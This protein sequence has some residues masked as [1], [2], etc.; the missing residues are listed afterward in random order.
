[1]VIEMLV[2]AAPNFRSRV[3][4]CI[5]GLSVLVG[6]DI[7][8]DEMQTSQRQAYLV[9]G[10]AQ[11]HYF[12]LRRGAYSR[13]VEPPGGPF[14]QR[15]GYSHL[16]QWTQ[17]LGEEDFEITWRAESSRRARLANHFGLY[18]IYRPT[19]QAGLTILSDDGVKLYDYG[20][21][22]FYFHDFEELPEL[23][24]TTLLFIENRELLEE[25]YDY[26]NPAVEW[27]RF[28]QAALLL[29]GGR[30]GLNTE[31][32][33]GSTLA[34][35]LEKFRHSPGG[36]TGDEREKARQMATATLRAYQA[37]PE[38]T[39]HRQGI[40]LDYVNE[41]P[42]AASPG[43]GEVLGLA[44]GLRVWFGAEPQEVMERLERIHHA[45]NQN[46]KTPGFLTEQ[47]L[48]D[49]RAYRM[50]LSLF[51]AHRRPSYY[52]RQRP[53]RLHQLT[54]SY[55]RVM[56]EQG[57]ISADLRDAILAVD[58]PVLQTAPPRARRE[59]AQEKSIDALRARLLRLLNLDD[60][61]ALDRVDLYAQSTIDEAAQRAVDARLQRM[62]DPEFLEEMNL[63]GHRL[64]SPNDPID[65]LTVSFTLYE[66]TSRGNALRV[67]ADNHDQ[68]LNINDHVKLDLGS[69]A[70]LR[71]LVTYLEVVADLYEELHA[72]RADQLTDLRT[73]APDR[74]RRWT[75]AQLIEHPQ[76]SLEEAL[77]AALDKPYSADP[78]ESFFT[79]GGLHRFSNFENRRNHTQ[80]VREAF[81]H[82]VNLVFIRMMRDIVDY[83]QWL[84]PDRM[85]NI[86]GPDD[87]EERR[88]MLT[89]FADREGTDFQRRFY[90]K[91]EGLPRDQILSALVEDRRL[92]ADALAMVA[93]AF[94]SLTD[95]QLRD[96]LAEHG[97]FEPD[98]AALTDWR[99]AYDLDELSWQDRGYLTRI[100]P[101][102]LWTAAWLY[103]NEG[104]SLSETLVASRQVR[105]EVYQWLFRTSRRGRQ[106]SRLRMELEAEA[107]HQIGHAWRRLGYPFD[108]LVPSLATSIG[109]SADRPTALAELVGII[110]NDGL[111][112]PQYRIDALVFAPHTPYEARLE[113]RRAQGEQVLR[114]EVARAARSALIDVVDGGTARRIDGA[115]LRA[116]G[117]PVLVGGK[118]GTGDHDHKIFDGRR[119]VESRPVHRTATFVFFLEERFFGTI[120][121]FASGE[122][123]GEFR[124]TSALPTMLMRG[125]YP[126]FS[127]LLER[128][129]ADPAPAAAPGG[130]LAA[131]VAGSSQTSVMR[132]AR[133][134][135]GSADSIADPLPL[136]WRAVLD[137][138]RPRDLRRR[139]DDDDEELQP[140]TEPRMDWHRLLAPYPG[141]DSGDA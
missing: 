19:P 126:H 36:V 98:Q 129:G 136:D 114:P 95:D 52:L 108:E 134:R 29:V 18:P 140:G 78:G 72:L 54:D 93:T 77:E 4:I 85:K 90:G 2:L 32:F 138:D 6:A 83:Y 44:D 60:L 104:A 75:A 21:P 69:T 67:L 71:T 65:E 17:D 9:A 15:R 70:K 131:A 58:T 34:T 130:P 22:Q 50:V 28:A 122:P 40:V 109:S 39:A 113:R 13:S 59:F 23:L 10:E 30:L 62:H 99:E 137:V 55:A 51:L 68:P 76:M 135:Y 139:R 57:I 103:E 42:L 105:Q 16:E 3:F 94:P 120:T 84:H 24:V 12:W 53:D 102:E 81:R 64:L 89:R 82:S 133:A 124:Y 49:A 11:Q 119:L 115:L 106:D 125:L 97:Q 25:G 141:D 118:T 73:H 31:H 127:H 100:H 128:P 117:E 111:R 86:L 7:V 8:Y 107:F 112:E 123:A 96:F 116:N 45:H 33:G 63:F 101:L 92:S 48:A 47:S 37:G 87:T 5:L 74:L 41:V 35:Q 110:A 46:A 79:G 61:Y 43:Y 91:F 132:A 27:R 26:R 1:M 38:T 14:D 121:V 80:S 56:A 20:T 66:R 88:Y